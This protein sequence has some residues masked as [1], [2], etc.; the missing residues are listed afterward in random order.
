MARSL[1]AA[2]A[3][4][5]FCCSGCGSGQT[6][7]AGSP[8]RPKV[9][10]LWDATGATNS[11][12][13]YKQELIS[14]IQHVAAEDGEVWAA[15]LDGQPITTAA[16]TARNFGEAPPGA[17]AQERSEINQ[18][19]AEGFARNFIATFTKPEVVRGSGQLQGL[20][21]ASRTSGVTEI[22]MWSDAIVN[23]PNDRFDLST[24]TVP[25]LNAEIAHWKPRFAGLKGTT[26]VVVGIGRA[27]HHVV[28]VERAHR[29]FQA[30]VAGNGARLIWVPTL[31]QR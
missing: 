7:T 26:V 25:E 20:L 17:Q 22:V 3:V 30:L 13:S 15:V 14:T 5:A 28:T 23:E 27:V 6:A 1:L 29:L 2:V 16:I 12:L 11:S 19:V 8:V 10:V 31:A 24:A 9:F 18:A 21:I 4:A